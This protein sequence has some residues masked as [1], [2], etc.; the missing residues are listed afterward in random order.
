M[1]ISGIIFLNVRKLHLKGDLI[2]NN[3]FINEDNSESNT[4]YQ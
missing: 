1:D 2:K 4:E 3:L